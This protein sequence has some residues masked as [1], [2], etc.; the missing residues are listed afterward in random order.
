MDKTDIVSILINCT[1]ITTIARTTSL[2]VYNNLSIKTNGR[3]H[4]LCVHASKYVES[5]SNSGGWTLG[6]TWTAILRNVL[7]LWPRHVV[8]TIHISPV[9]WCWDCV[10]DNIPSMSWVLLFSTFKW[11]TR[12][13]ATTHFV[14]QKFFSNIGRSWSWGNRLRESINCFIVKH[15]VLLCLSCNM[16]NWDGPGIFWCSPSTVRLNSDVVDTA[17]DT[18]ETI[19]SPMSTPW[20]SDSPKLL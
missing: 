1:W 9:N 20:V 11:S 13:T 3:V 19:F 15:G 4:S 14:C 7:V 8:N 2:A 6:P 10:S 5:V 16:F 12:N 17:A 18:E